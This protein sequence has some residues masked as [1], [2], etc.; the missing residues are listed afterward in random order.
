MESVVLFCKSYAND[1]YRVVRLTKSIQKYNND[2]IP[3]FISVP[4]EDETLFRQHLPIG[5]WQLITDE[6]IINISH[7]QAPG[8]R[9]DDL[10]AH[11]QQQFV[12]SEFWRLA[13]CENYLVLDSDSFFIRPFFQSDFLTDAGIPY[14]VCHENKEIRQFAA[15]NNRP[16]ITEGFMQE[17]Q[18]IQAQFE[19]KGRALDYG[20]TPCIWSCQVWKTLSQQFAAPK[21]LSFADLLQRVPSELLWYGEAVI[22]LRPIP[23]IPIEPLFKVFH[24]Q[25]QLQENQKYFKE[26]EKTWA[27]D[28]LG[29]IRQSNW[30]F[31]LD[32]VPRKR[33]SWRTLWLKKQ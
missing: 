29:I 13:L 31:E 5:G 12:K 14:T 18:N 26:S 4:E 21:G 15:R 16:K 7:K 2:R 11:V 24:F 6:Q 9:H 23:L 33:R 28:Y 1:V 30:E 22:N 19:R 25:Q 27:K 20:P 3:F 17:R 32:Y 10:P 8:L